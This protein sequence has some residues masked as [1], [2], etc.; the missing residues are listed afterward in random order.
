MSKNNE[1]YHQN[2]KET[3][4]ALRGRGE[5]QEGQALYFGVL[6]STHF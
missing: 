3:G 1:G 2:G 4:P 6:P 5:G